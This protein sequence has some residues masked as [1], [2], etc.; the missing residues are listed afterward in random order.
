MGSVMF[1]SALLGAVIGFCCG[2]VLF[3]VLGAGVGFLFGGVVGVLFG[4]LL[5]KPI[6][7]AN[8]KIVELERRVERLESE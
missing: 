8:R 7:E 3:G 1:K 2:L 5:L 6:E 4:S